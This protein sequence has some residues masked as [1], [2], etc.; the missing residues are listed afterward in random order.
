MVI[1]VMSLFLTE[2]EGSPDPSFP[3]LSD[4]LVFDETC[5]PNTPG[6]T[7]GFAGDSLVSLDAYRKSIGRSKTSLWRYRR[8]GWL[9][10]VNIFGRLYVKRADVLAFETA[11]AQGLLAR[12]PHGCAQQKEAAGT[13][14]RT[15]E[16]PTHD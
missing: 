1:D 14:Q 5:D 16:E 12:P 4:G 9:P 6:S 11:A 8:S 2:Y 13:G 15:S 7:D 10:V 3:L